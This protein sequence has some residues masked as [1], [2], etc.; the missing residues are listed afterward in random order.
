MTAPVPERDAATGL[1][2]RAGFLHAADGLRAVAVVDVSLLGPVTDVLGARGARRA[3]PVASARLAAACSGPD[4]IP[5]LELPTRL[6]GDT[7][8]VA[9][10]ADDRGEALAAALA[11]RERSARA[12]VVDG[13]PFTPAVCVGVAL[14]ADLPP[15]VRH[16]PASARVRTLLAR[17][18]VARLAARTDRTVCCFDDTLGERADRRVEI[19]RGFGSAV[20]AGGLAVHF[21]PV[22]SLV[23]DAVLGVE[24]LVR[25]QHPELGL[26]MPD[27]FVP[28]LET[29]GQV[30]TLTAVVLE[31]S[32]D[33]ARGWL[34]RGLRLGVAVNVP[35]AQLDDPAFPETVA[36]AL[37]RH[38]VPAEL[39]TLELTESGCPSDRAAA[40]PVLRRLR[41]IGCR[42]SLDDFGTGQSSLAHLRV[43]PVDQLKIDKS[44]VLAVDSDPD[45]AAVV[46]AVVAMGHA[47]GLTVVAEGVER[48]SVRT[49]LAAVGCDAAQ[50]F[51]VARG[52]SRED[53]RRWLDAR[54]VRPGP[55][56]EGVPAR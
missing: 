53:L 1:L 27:E 24:A 41:G 54:E 9:L 32:L 38:G 2:S 50:G 30:S 39:L 17:A 46:R 22:V 37:A 12:H 36:D 25:W 56:G 44:F 7:F 29:T 23:D 5:G 10:R 42:L 8:A 28:V 52:M 35:V 43:L 14:P 49:A 16:G 45:D 40:L 26:L 34:D 4:A 51:G 20:D 3:V 47:L 48:E 11:V 19:V 6:G 21:Q 33:A 31:A 18:D 13:V 15:G 55:S